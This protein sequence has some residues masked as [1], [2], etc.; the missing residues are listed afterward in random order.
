M[1][2]APIEEG[3]ISRIITGFTWRL[4]VSRSSTDAGDAI[5][6]HSNT[7]CAGEQGIVYGSRADGDLP[8]LVHY[9]AYDTWASGADW[10]VSLPAGEEPVL[11][12]AGGK[13][14]AN[15][16]EV[17]SQNMGSVVV[18]TSRG[19][20]RFFTGSGVQRYLWRMGEEMVSMVASEEMVLL[21]HREGGTSLDGMS[22]SIPH[23]QTH[24]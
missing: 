2:R 4:S 6:A 9:R 10:Q 1:T 24:G 20:I 12:A 3:I 16:F 23:G 17:E 14:L 19:F 11:L 18:A 21:V 7:L 15:E 22:P 8:A 13:P 5:L